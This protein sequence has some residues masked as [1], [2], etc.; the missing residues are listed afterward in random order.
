MSRHTVPACYTVRTK[1]PTTEA[2]K[3]E[4][5]TNVK[6]MQR[7]PQGHNTLPCQR[8]APEA[9]EIPKAAEEV[10]ATRARAPKPR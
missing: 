2:Q 8:K 3:K 5:G 1:G 10:W 6:A 9:S 4:N 7:D